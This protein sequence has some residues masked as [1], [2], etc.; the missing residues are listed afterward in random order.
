MTK[1]P[2]TMNQVSG[3]PVKPSQCNGFSGT[4]AQVE[5]TACSA[6]Y[7]RRPAHPCIQSGVPERGADVQR[8]E[9]LVWAAEHGASEV[10]S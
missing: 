3:G 4:S 5:D 2:G 6:K 8:E 9:A 7:E 1:D 10:A